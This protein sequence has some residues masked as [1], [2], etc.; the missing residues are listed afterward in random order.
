MTT[1]A[2]P[3]ALAIRNLIGDLLGRDVTVNPADPLV[4]ADLPRTVTAVYVDG[5][6]RMSAIIGLDL[7]LAAYA[8]AA[9]GL[10]PPG[11]AEDCIEDGVLSPII[12]ENVSELFNVMT[13]LLNRAGSRHLKLYKVILP[14]ETAP[15]DAQSLLLAWGNR[16]DL[17]VEVARYGKGRFSLSVAT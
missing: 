7:S 6:I 12:A 3:A 4:S 2:L 16:L 10:M 8:G 13:S 15:T 1:T 11:G 5:S 17:E 14:P 9:L